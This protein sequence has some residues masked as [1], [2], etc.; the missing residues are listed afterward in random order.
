[1]HW[2]GSHHQ[3]RK[4]Q[5]RL[6]L[7]Q[8]ASGKCGGAYLYSNQ[9]GCDGNRLYFDGRSDYIH[10]V[11]LCRDHSMC[12]CYYYC[13]YYSLSSSL[14]C[15]NGSLLC[16]GSQFGLRDVEVLS[17]LVDLDDVRTFRNKS[18]SVQE[19]SSAAAA[20]R[21]YPI[22]DLRHFSLAGSGHGSRPATSPVAVSLHSAEEECCLGPACWLWDYLRR[23]GASGYLLPLSG[24]ADSA[25]VAGIVKVMCDLVVSEVGKGNKEVADDALRIV[26]GSSDASA[27]APDALAI[28]AD[29][30]CNALLHTVY[31]STEN[32]SQNTRSRA[33]RIAGSIGAFHSALAIDL[34]ISVQHLAA[35]IASSSSSASSLR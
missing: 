12:Y 31:M 19:Q 33:S 34:I 32:S 35:K 4:L 17:A 1:M 25:A 9:R 5:S 29:S 27:A 3:L 30:L 16:Q 7:V 20:A 6:S 8:G 21:V 18:A 2:A 10:P 11:Y 15:L 26:N 24:G 23:S 28:S 22:I 14:I 13:Y